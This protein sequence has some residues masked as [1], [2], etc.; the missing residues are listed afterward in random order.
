MTE[1]DQEQK[2]R[3]TGTRA[4]TKATHKSSKQT[5]D[6]KSKEKQAQQETPIKNQNTKGEG[7]VT[8]FSTA[9]TLSSLFPLFCRSVT[10]WTVDSV[11]QSILQYLGRLL[12]S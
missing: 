3:E 8:F 4:Q 9:C 1:R 7:H 11:H 10:R 5:H 12:A 6:N 2:Q